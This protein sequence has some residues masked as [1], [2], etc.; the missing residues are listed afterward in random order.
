MEVSKGEVGTQDGR[1]IYAHGGAHDR[2]RV[3]RARC[4]PMINVWMFITSGTDQ[5]LIPL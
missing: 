4:N 2:P 1:N 3:L 5:R